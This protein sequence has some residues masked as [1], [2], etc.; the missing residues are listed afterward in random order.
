MD[1]KKTA[2]VGCGIMGTGIAQQIAVSGYPVVLYGRN[3]QKAEAAVGRI[4]AS[5][6]RSADK[7][8][9]PQEAVDPAVARILPTN[10]LEDISGAD[11]VVEAISENLPLKQEFFEKM[12]ALCGEKCILATNTSALSITEIAGRCR[13]PGRVIGLHF[14]HPVAAMKLVEIV[15]GRE[16][17]EEVYQ[18]ARVFCEKIGRICVRLNTDAPGFIVNRVLFAYFLECIHIYEEGI[19][20]KEDIDTAIRYGLNHPLGPFRLMDMGGLDTFPEVCASLQKIDQER[21][22][23]PESILKLREEGKYGSKTGEGWYTYGK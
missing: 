6:Q 1:I 9:M 3:L 8:R 14:F 5:L 2:V 10:R 7:G 15:M 18:D 21:F 12:D 13:F 19:A 23:C 4:R 16:T 11:L 20:S 22:T 17:E